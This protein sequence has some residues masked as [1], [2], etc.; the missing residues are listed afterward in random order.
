[1]EGG[2]RDTYGNRRKTH[3]RKRIYFRAF[4]FVYFGEKLFITLLRH[5]H[6]RKN[7][8]QKTFGAFRAPSVPFPDL[9]GHQRSSFDWLLKNGL[10]ELFKE[11]SPIT[12]YS[13]KKFELEFESFEI[14]EPKYDAEFARENMRTYEAPVR[15][16]VKLV[17]KTFGSEKSQE[18]FLTDMPIMT[19]H[20]SFIVSGV[21]RAIVPQLA[22]SF[23]AFFVSELIRGKPYFGAKIIPS[24]GAWLEFETESSGV[25]SVRIDRKRKVPVTAFLRSSFLTAT[26]A[27]KAL[28]ALP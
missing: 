7:L 10:S 12:D 3:K 18:I 4:A 15:A 16:T 2:Q 8:V 5:H 20:G 13:G 1:M 6:M 11:F 9:V 21:E 25:I 26:A 19:P 24:R 28:R 14:G 27:S 23:G 17:N 22:R